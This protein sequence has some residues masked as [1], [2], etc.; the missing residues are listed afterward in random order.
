MTESRIFY[1]IRTQE[2]LRV[3]KDRHVFSLFPLQTWL[4]LMQ[5]VGFSVEKHPYPVRDDGREAYL[6][7]GTWKGNM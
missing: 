1:L 4:D 3:E 6:L 7:V 5:D 2:G